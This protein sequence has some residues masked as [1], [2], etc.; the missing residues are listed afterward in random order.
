MPLSSN[1]FSR[2]TS[3][4]RDD[5]H[6][7]FPHALMTLTKFETRSAATGSTR[8]RNAKNRENK[9]AQPPKQVPAR[10]NRTPEPFFRSKGKNRAP[11][12]LFEPDAAP[13]QPARRANSCQGVADAT[14]SARWGCARPRHHRNPKRASSTGRRDAA[15]ATRAPACRRARSPRFM[16]QFEGGNIPAAAQPDAGYSQEASQRR[17]WSRKEDDAIMRLVHPRPRRNL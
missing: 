3:C 5:L 17:A 13:D 15:A 6:P 2:T 8:K 14:S 1:F 10:S 12:G 4:P 7:T 16:E 11:K 9:Q